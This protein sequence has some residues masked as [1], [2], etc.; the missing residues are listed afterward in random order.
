MLGELEDVCGSII[1]EQM[2]PFLNPTRSHTQ[3]CLQAC[4]PIKVIM[5]FSSVVQIIVHAAL[6][7]ASVALLKN[8]AILG[9]AL[10]P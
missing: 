7:K 5:H 4:H 2:T 1:N 8:V 10:D 6:N 3:S 9:W